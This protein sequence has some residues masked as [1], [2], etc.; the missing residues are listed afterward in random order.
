MTAREQGDLPGRRVVTFGHSPDADDAF[1]F[2]GIA[3]GKVA[4]E[5][6][7]VEH[8]M[9]DIESLNRRAA[10]GDLDVTAISA[11]HYPAVASSYRIMSCGASVGRKYGPVMVSARPIDEKG[12]AGLRIAVP[13]EYTTSYMLCRI[14][15]TAPFTPVFMHFDRVTDAVLEGKAD[16]GILLHEGQ[17]LFERQG[18]HKVLDLGERWFESTG[19][20]IPLGLDVV[21]RRLGPKLSQAATDALRR[22]I[23]YARA[24]EDAALDYALSFGR[25]IS[26]EDGRRFVRMYVNDDTV[27]MGEEGRRALDTLYSRA[28]DQ[29]LITG[30]PP[31]DLITAAA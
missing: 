31:L 3:T 19:L 24:N 16:A 20:P 7:A 6:H 5:G 17:I 2:F 21:H 4:I 8:V 15:V 14:F 22:S 30:N 25:G 28:S 10:T 13:G 12:L 29:G 23:E 11:A 1:M 9:E 18:L 26:K 27:D